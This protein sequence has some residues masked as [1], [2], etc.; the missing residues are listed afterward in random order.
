M[1]TVDTRNGGA[2]GA[3]LVAALIV[4]A[5]VGQDIRSEEPAGEPD[6]TTAA[7]DASVE[8]TPIGDATGDATLAPK[9]DC[10]PGCIAR[11]PVGW[12][13]PVAVTQGE[14]TGAEPSCAAPYT[15]EALVLG[16]GVG[17][18]PA[19]CSSCAT[20]PTSDLCRSQA[21]EYTTATCD[22]AGNTFNVDVG[23]NGTS[24]IN[25]LGKQGLKVKVGPVGT[26]EPP[27]QSPTF[28]PASFA[29]RIKACAST[30]LTSC[31]NAPGCATAP[32]PTAPFGKLCV[33]KA[34]DVACPSEDYAVKHTGF[35]D[36]TDTRSC[37]PCTAAIVS[38]CTGTPQL[39]RWTGST[40][41]GTPTATTTVNPAT[42]YSLVG[43][44][45]WGVPMGSA[46]SCN[47]GGGQPT[48]G[49]VGKDPYTVCCQP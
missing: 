41:T 35:T 45:T 30:E 5:C 49:V 34:G 20:T 39:T 29:T 12:T 32:I 1:V 3:G 38:G 27:A 48:G 14:G 37:S 28:A 46:P 15:T 10:P 23:P 22:G 8:A 19:T 47:V 43:Q 17:G 40:C 42:C 13:G 6:A 33:Y 24:C 9:V 31:T 2:V 26:C 36:V 16:D 7:G 11:A 21:T 25:V 44:T 18:A 4:A